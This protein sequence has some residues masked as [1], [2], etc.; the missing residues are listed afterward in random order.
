MIG[1]GRIFTQYFTAL[2]FKRVFTVSLGLSGVLSIFDLLA[3]AGE[4][5]QNSSQIF[6][7][8][9]QYILLR[10]P[11]IL[12]V[13]LPLACLL[14]ALSVLSQKVTNQEIIA[15]R[16]V[17]VSI[18]QIISSFLI[19]GI[20]IGV[21]HFL[22]LNFVMPNSSYK[23]YL[24]SQNDYSGTPPES[25]E[26]G[27]IPNWIATGD[28]IIKLEKASANGKI[29][30]GVS[31]FN[32]DERGRLKN[33]L[34]AKRAT[35]KNNAW[36]LE[37]IHY[38][39]SLSTGITTEKTILNLPLKPS[40]FAKSIDYKNALAVHDLE[41]LINKDIAFE[42]PGYV[43]K[44]WLYQKYAISFSSIVMILLAAP[45][46][47]QLARSQ[48]MM[49]SQFIIILSGFAFFISDRLITSFGEAGYLPPLLAVSAIPVFFILISF[50][51]L[52]YKE[53]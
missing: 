39:G 31:I 35:F 1:A 52:L 14:S 37:K 30:E 2:F 17:G 26:S 32:R 50:W 8:L 19:A 29:I 25:R 5:T 23:L 7:P 21:L 27:Q 49:R 6:I 43:Y 11:E 24:W 22:L 34:T 4:I 18:Y 48:K 51:W 44:L 42:K 53:G 40:Y 15:V 46:G 9:S 13:V 41:K 3:N 45:I 28:T 16:S 12:S 10:Y 33:Y 38:P 47:L 36:H 20:I